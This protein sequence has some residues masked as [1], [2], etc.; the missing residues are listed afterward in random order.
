LNNFTPSNGIIRA[1][2]WQIVNIPSRSF[3]IFYFF[4]Q[5]NISPLSEKTFFLLTLSAADF[6]V[7]FCV[8]ARNKHERLSASNNTPI[9]GVGGSMIIF[10][11]FFIHSLDGLKLRQIEFDFFRFASICIHNR[12]GS[13]CFV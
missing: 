8:V 10:K 9:H 5:N 1:L 12:A 7:L 13:A 2:C 4:W 11:C 3:V 6:F